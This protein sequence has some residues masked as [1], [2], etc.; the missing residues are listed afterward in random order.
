MKASDY[1]AAFLAEQ[2]VTTVYEMTGGMITHML[3]SLGARDDIRV[4]SVHHEQAA[5]FAAEAGARMTGVPGVAMA[6]SGPGATNLITG[7]GSCFFDSVPAVFITGQVNTHELRGDSGVRQAGFQ[8]TDIVAVATPL[9][10]AAWQVASAIEL[11]GMLAAAFRL[12]LEGRPGPVLVDIPMNV[13]REDVDAVPSR[14]VSPAAGAALGLPEVLEALASSQRPLILAGGGVRAAGATDAVRALAE[15]LDIPVASSLMGVDVLPFAHPLHVGMIGT[16]GNR[17]ANLAMRDAD[18]LLLL[19]ARLDVRQTGAD[20]ESFRAGKKLLRVDVDGAQSRWRVPADIDVRADI[21]VFARLALEGVVGAAQTDRSEWRDRIDSYRESWPDSGELAQGDG[22]NPATFM[23]E[24]SAHGETVSAYV[25]DVGQ[26]QMWAAQ[27]LRLREG[28]R[29]LTSGGM[30]AMGFSLPSAIGAA[31]AR[32]GAPVVAIAGDGGL[33]VN[34]QE[35]ETVARLGLPLKI[36]VMNNRCLGM[37]RQFQDE[38]FDS[39]YQ[40]TVWGYGA[41]DF[42]AVSEA[43]GIPARKVERPSDVGAALVWLMDDPAACGLLEVELTT[44][45]CVRPKVSFGSPV[46]EMDPPPSADS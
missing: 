5:A 24:L 21:D 41:P 39:R 6:T 25:A 28:Q 1:I 20:V 4:V 45:S 30:G 12:A 35:L 8:E 7:I 15:A 16:Y 19:G 46:Y 23:H 42:V 26:N 32:P 2:G 27:S 17:W 18:C 3:D 40:S 10:K 9:T 43:F 37:V 34:I 31:L 38:L 33:Q 22:I 14:V 11:P 29:F 13:Q 36:I 44:D